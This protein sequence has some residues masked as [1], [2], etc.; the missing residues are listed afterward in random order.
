[1]KP[2]QDRLKKIVSDRGLTAHGF[3]IKYGFN[4]STISDILEGR[5]NPKIDTLSKIAECLEISLAE[6]LCEPEEIEMAKCKRT[7]CQKM[8]ERIYNFDEGTRNR[9]LGYMD[10][11]SENARY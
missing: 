4:V 6:L 8:C 2:V 1:M 7:D 5:S 3:A 9:V 11:L 10:C